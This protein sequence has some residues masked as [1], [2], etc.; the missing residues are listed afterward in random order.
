MFPVNLMAGDINR[1][2]QKNSISRIIC[3]YDSFET[4]IIS[5]DFCIG[6]KC[7]K[8]FKLLVLLMKSPWMFP[9]VW[10]HWLKSGVVYYFPGN[11]SLWKL[12]GLTLN[13]RIGRHFKPCWVA[14]TFVRVLADS[15]SY[16]KCSVTRKQHT[17]L[18]GRE[19]SVSLL[20]LC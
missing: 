18:G 8:C 15:W 19:D 5:D 11:V 10:M 13:A 9:Q 14:N 20:C 12:L 17:S 2:P 1:I 3:F 6:M 7:S 16:D 4:S